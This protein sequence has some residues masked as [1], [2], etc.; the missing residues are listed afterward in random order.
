MSKKKLVR[1][2]SRSQA[3][4]T[5]RLRRPCK[6][7]P[8]RSDRSFGGLRRGHAEE[9]VEN[10]LGS[11]GSFHCHETTVHGVDEDDN[12][13]TTV[14]D[15]SLPCV[16]GLLFMEHVRPEGA[17]GNM[18]VVL[19]RVLGKPEFYTQ[20]LDKSFPVCKSPEEFYRHACDPRMLSFL[21][22]L[23]EDNSESVPEQ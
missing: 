18:W 13:V 1:R 11:A 17:I 20:D 5:P 4:S 2:S 19:G 23:T 8:F 10:L 21:D 6:N 3:P 15:N 9:I 12:P 22:W 16:G 14:D 7:C